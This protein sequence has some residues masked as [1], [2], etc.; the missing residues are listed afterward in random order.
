MVNA[1][2]PYR[3]CGGPLL[4]YQFYGEHVISPLLIWFES[5]IFDSTTSKV[6]K[7]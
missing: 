1:Y 5:L 4:N 3:L 7:S 2:P 6:F